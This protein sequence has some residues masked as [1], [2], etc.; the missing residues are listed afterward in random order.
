MKCCLEPTNSAIWGM[1]M[2]VCEQEGKWCFRPIKIGE[3]Y[4]TKKTRGLDSCSQQEMRSAHLADMSPWWQITLPD[5]LSRSLLCLPPSQH[6]SLPLSSASFSCA[7]LL[8]IQLEEKVCDA[9]TSRK[10]F[11]SEI[12]KILLKGTHY[13]NLDGLNAE[14]MG[15]DTF[16]SCH[17]MYSPNSR[18]VGTFCKMQ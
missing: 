12:Q 4:H 15:Y 8:H 5:S 17:L 3:I 6:L 9:L 2:Y 18:K 11:G 13:T 10:K 1:K 16:T 7:V 14:S